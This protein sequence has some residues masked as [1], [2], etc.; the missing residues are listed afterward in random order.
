LV[1]PAG[2]HVIELYFQPDAYL[3]GNKVTLIA[4]WLLLIIVVGC[5]GWSWRRNE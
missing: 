4:S 5:V 3:I 2:Q 1:I